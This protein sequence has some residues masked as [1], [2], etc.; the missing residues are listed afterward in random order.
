MTEDCGYS[1]I[2]FPRALIES[3]KFSSV[4][5]DAKL[6]FAL[7]LE[8]LNLSEIN[9]ERYTDEKGKTYVIFTVEEVN[10]K[11]SCSNTRT[12][13]AFRELEA[14]NLIERKRK[15]NS[16][17]YRIY[18][19]DSFF[20]FLKSEFRNSENVNSGVNKTGTE[21]FQNCEHSYIENN[22]IDNNYNNP[23]I[24]VTEDEIKEQIEYDCI[25]HEDNRGILNEIVM[26]MYEVYNGLSDTVRIGKEVITRG[27]AIKRFRTLD[28]EHIDFV[29][30][31]VESNGI[32]IK[33]IKSYLLTSL[34]NAPATMENWVNSIFSYYNNQ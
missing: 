5:V 6:L 21:E 8:R 26:L 27:D 13:K 18:V 32:Q 12:I 17:P 33:N 20:E 16:S 24:R 29:I 4:S 31:N 23:S 1:F 11:L 15:I 25:V 14:N 9:S 2:K 34:Y 30:S 19:L 28:S 7:I 3:E 10:R 22:Y